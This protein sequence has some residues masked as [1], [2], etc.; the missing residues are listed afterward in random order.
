[1]DIIHMNKLLELQNVSKHFSVPG[2]NLHAVDNVSFSINRGETLGIVGE[3]GCGKSTLGR[4][5]LRLH[6]PSGGRIL[7][8]GMDIT[9]FSEEEMRY[10]RKYMQIIFQDPYA[11]LDPRYTISQTIEEPLKIHK[12]YASDSERKARVRELM[13]M[14][15]LSGRVMN[16]YPHEF[17]GGRRQRVV[18]ARALAID[19]RF[20]VCDEPVSALDVSVQAQI[21]NL[22]MEL[23]EK[24]GLTYI[25]ISHD[26]S[27]IKHISS[28]IAVMYL[29]EIVEY[30]PKNEIFTKPLH[31]Y[32]IALLSAVPSVNI[33]SKKQ[34]IILSGEIASPVNPGPGCR[35]APRCPFASENCTASKIPLM[36]ASPGHSVA[37]LRYSELLAG[38]IKFFSGGIQ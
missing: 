11:S 37:C 26:L 21:L 31:P 28:N 25:F 23:Q 7:Y 33:R 8:D 9:S 20:I 17:D 35:F 16:A 36:E 38:E 19:P 32:T 6:E 24:L 12:V 4:V 22:M 3:S 18:I 27:V 13:E 15:G 29:G 1:M 2:G 34:R 14:V 5:I 10:M 30:S